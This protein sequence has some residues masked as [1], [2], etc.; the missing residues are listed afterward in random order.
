MQLA[1]ST[2]I[3]PQPIPV[4]DELGG[5]LRQ[6]FTTKNQAWNPGPNAANSTTAIG[7][8]AS[9]FLEG[10]RQSYSARFYNPI[11]GRFMSRDPKD[12]RSF[13]P[14]GN[15]IDPKAMHKYLYANG[16]PVNGLDPTGRDDEEEE[17]RLSFIPFEVRIP[18]YL[19][20]AI[21]VTYCLEFAELYSHQGQ[22]YNWWPY[23]IDKLAAYLYCMKTINYGY[24]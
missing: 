8:R 9:L 21:K 2:T 11:T 7:L 5:N 15:P 17:P 13:D 22:N 24:N 3:T 4:W 10:I 20:G 23:G 12:P 1:L 16:D 19:T 14:A 6:G 18:K